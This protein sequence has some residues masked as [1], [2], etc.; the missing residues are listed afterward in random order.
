MKLLVVKDYEEM[1]K[2]AAETFKEV[3]NEKPEAILGLAT[4]STPVGLYKYLIEM[5]K[6]KE[7]DFSKIKTV[8]LDEYVGLGEENS[9]SYRYFMNEN[10]FNHVNINKSNTFVPNGLAKDLNEE[11]KN[12]DKRIDELGGID[13]QILGIGSNGH[14]AFNEPDEF[15]IS[16]THVTNLAQST[17]EANSRFFNS[18]EEV[19]TK[20]ISMGIGQIMKAKKILLLVKGEDKADAIK[21]LLNGNITT[22]NPATIL[23]LHKDVIVIIDEKMAEKIK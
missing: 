11:T 18:I 22:S 1:S 17:I 21:E 4:G 15:L 16:E 9:Q 23:K 5:N 14:I 7:I 6:N 20:A 12:Y 8:N 13:L 2:V 10:L 19:P 3:I